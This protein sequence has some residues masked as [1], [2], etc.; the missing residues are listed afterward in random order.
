MNLHKSNCQFWTVRMCDNLGPYI[1][2]R[3]STWAKREYVC[4]WW[5]WW[6]RSVGQWATTGAKNL[7]DWHA[8]VEHKI[9]QG[10]QVY[11]L[12]PWQVDD[13]RQTHKLISLSGWNLYDYGYF[14]QSPVA[15]SAVDCST[16]LQHQ[17]HHFVL[18]PHLRSSISFAKS[19]SSFASSHYILCYGTCFEYV[20]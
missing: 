5:W 14:K 1:E 11:L 17:P 12:L 6:A 18:A 9:T 20:I 16:L 19:S 15:S 4:N 2:F 3:A 13:D 8:A 10:R 7:T